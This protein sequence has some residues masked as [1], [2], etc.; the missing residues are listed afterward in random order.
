MSGI[1]VVCVMPGSRAA[2]AGVLM[3]DLILAFNGMRTENVGDY[4]KAKALKPDK[5]SV[6]VERSGKKLYFEW[7][8]PGGSNE[9]KNRLC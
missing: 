4:I 7:D 9:S 3:G 6:L 2:D 1:R 8:N 5:E